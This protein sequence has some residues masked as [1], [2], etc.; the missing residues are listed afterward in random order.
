MISPGQFPKECM[1]NFVNYA[2]FECE[3][4]IY[5]RLQTNFCR[6]SLLLHQNRHIGSPDRS[7]RADQI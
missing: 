1:A 4:V 5:F 7:P 2:L 3:I 6:R